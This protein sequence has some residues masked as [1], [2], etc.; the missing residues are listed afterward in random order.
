MVE[1]SVSQLWDN[2]IS[3]TSSYNINL[4][5]TKWYVKHAEAYIKSIKLSVWLTH[6]GRC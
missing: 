1:Q 4:L 3:K 2:F 5:A 6:C